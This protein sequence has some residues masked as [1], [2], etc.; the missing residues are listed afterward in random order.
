[1][2]QAKAYGAYDGSNLR[3]FRVVRKC[4]SGYK[5]GPLFADSAEIWE[6]LFSALANEAIGEPL[7]LDAPENNP[8]AIDLAKRHGMKEVF[9]FARMYCG[10]APNLPW[11][12]ILE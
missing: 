3:G 6:A 11:D 8:A 10:F 5:I 12:R 1:M 2:K 4:L 7:I 9:G